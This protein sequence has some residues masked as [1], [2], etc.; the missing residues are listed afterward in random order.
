MN[1]IHIDLQTIKKQLKSTL[2]EIDKLNQNPDFFKEYLTNLTIKSVENNK[3]TLVTKN[4][5]SKQIIKNDYLNKITTIFNQNNS[6]M[7]FVFDVISENENKIQKIGI[8][9]INFFNEESGVNK[10]YTFDNFIIG[11]FNKEAVIASKSI[12]TD[13]FINPLFICANVGLGKTHLLHAIGNLFNQ[14]FPHKSIKYI[15]SDD[16][17]REIYKAFNSENKMEIE[18]VKTKYEKYDLLLIDDIQILSNMDK[19]RQILFT[20][21]NNNIINNKYIVWTS[22]T[23][24][25]FLKNFETRMKSRLFSGVFTTIKKPDEISLKNIAIQKM[26]ALDQS[27]TFNNEALEYIVH[28]NNG[29]IRRLEGQVNQIFFFVSNNSQ[30]LPIVTLEMV[31]TIFEPLNKN[32]IKK[33]G[34]DVDPNIVIDQVALSYSVNAEAIKSKS[35]V[36]KLIN[37]R[38]VCMYVLRK[39]FNMTYSQ[40]GQL[41]SGRDHSTVM[42][43]INKIEKILN[44]D[45][46]LKN[47]IEKIY[48]KI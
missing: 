15:S 44:K 12:A 42:T 40:I 19:I 29:D 5:F 11:E 4:N 9:Q 13:S 37:P 24:P 1:M 3:I 34:Y 47:T 27:L 18:N 38:N 22:D 30:S 41:F 31:K 20:I 2:N 8:K 7:N 25:D 23:H 21:F 6:L 39:K 48:L 16:F 43:A 10:S 28:R 36:S 26:K 17:S 32:E 45:L 14:T 35:R 33:Y 46:D